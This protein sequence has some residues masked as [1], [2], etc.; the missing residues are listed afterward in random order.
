MCSGGGS[1]RCASLLVGTVTRAN[2][3]PP[4]SDVQEWSEGWMK[5]NVEI[6][7]RIE[8]DFSYHAPSTTAIAEMQGLRDSARLLAHQI[9]FLVPDG[10]EKSSALTKLE[11]VVMHANAGIARNQGE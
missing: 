11:E 8:R 9:N 4:V 7:K 1:P 5:T 6:Q 3:F 2:P 10:R